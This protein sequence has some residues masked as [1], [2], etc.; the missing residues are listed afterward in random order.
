MSRTAEYFDLRELETMTGQQRENFA[1]VVLKEL[2]D[3]GLDAAESVKAAPQLDVRVKLTRRFLF[4]AVRDFGP[5]IPVDTVK[6]ILNFQTRTS[7]KIAYRSPTRGAQGNALKT[8]FGIPVALGCP[9]PVVIEARGVRHVIRLS[10]DPAGEV[11]LDRQPQEVP[12]GPGTLMIVPLPIEAAEGFRPVWWCRAFSLFN[13]HA[14]VRIRKQDRRGEHANQRVAVRGNSYHPAVSFPGNGWRK[15]L[16]T[17]KTSPWWYTADALKKLIFL[18]IN[19]A[20][21]GE[22][23]LPLRK[24][25]RQFRG[26][27]GTAE[28]K[29]VCDEFPNLSHLSDFEEREDRVSD[30]LNAMRAEAKAPSDGVLGLIGKDPIR[31]RFEQWYGVKRLWYHKVDGIVDGVPFV[32]EAAVAETERPGQLFH[33]VNFSPTFEDPL[34]SRLL[35]GA[36]FLATGINGFLEAGHAYPL[37]RSTK[38]NL[39]A[40]AHLIW[41]APLFLDKGKTRLKVPEVIGQEVAGCLWKVSKTLY[42]E[43]ERRRKNAVSQDRAD[44]ERLRARRPAE[45]DLKEAVSRVLKGAVKHA[46][47]D[48]HP[49]SAHTLFYS[50][51]PLVQK[52]TERELVS[53]Y[54]EQT[55]LPAYQREHGAILL[56]D[57]R[58]AVYYE[59][60]GT[61]YEPH[62]DREVPL[63]TR[64]VEAY[65]FPA[66]LYD[67]ILF[68]EKKGLWPVLKSARL[69]ERYD[70]AIVAGEGYATEACRVLFKS[71]DREQRYQIFVLHDADP[72]GC[73]I[74]RTLREETVRMPGYRVE[75]IDL[76]LRLQQALDLGLATET[77]TRRKALPSGLKLEGIELEYFTGTQQTSGKSPCWLCQ[78]VELNAFN[79][80]SFIFYIETKLEATGVRGKVIPADAYL[81]NH[82]QNKYVGELR[83]LAEQAV[84]STLDFEA[85]INQ[86]LRAFPYD[87]DTAKAKDAIEKEFSDGPHLPWRHVIEQWIK[88]V[89]RERVDD[90]IEAKAE[91]LIRQKLLEKEGGDASPGA[92]GSA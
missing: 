67:K 23:D 72:Y 84:R 45:I 43:E 3:N 42:G 32:F 39:A 4:L 11:R 52:F 69:A 30:L 86:V 5:G 38:V 63:G 49:V 62:T 21:N 17:D 77:F 27:T 76:G 59:P 80:P 92:S 37:S 1:A 12:P 47:G 40:V 57:D 91:A 19:A 65:D 56:P 9:L 83:R 25:V 29:R 64:E 60:R 88:K 68:V 78:R 28:A 54:F 51:R 7:D 14:M 16:P 66:H 36:K 70:M 8:I 10:I 20:R 61:L 73:N 15:F 31:Q 85:L 48:R 44:R 33:G 58:P 74:A 24:F 53:S 55:L 75:I 81:S 34:A 18:H 71:A 6:R 82:L 2:A 22:E 41:P 26:L 13:P 50:V 90:Q 89:V 46:T 87:L 35:R 79:A